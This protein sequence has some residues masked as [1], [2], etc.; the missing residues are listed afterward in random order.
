MHTHE[1]RPLMNY[2]EGKTAKETREGRGQSDLGNY[3][4]LIPFLVFVITYCSILSFVPIRCS[5]SA[6]SRRCWVAASVI[7]FWLGL[8]FILNFMYDVPWQHTKFL[9]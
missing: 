8:Y 2:F 4:F 7:L 1:I 5:I 9:R 3:I 6:L